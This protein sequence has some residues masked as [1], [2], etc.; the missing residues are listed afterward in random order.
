MIPILKVHRIFI[1]FSYFM[2]CCEHRNRTTYVLCQK[3]IA[4]DRLLIFKRLTLRF[5]TCV[6]LGEGL[7]RVHTFPFFFFGG[8]QPARSES[9]NSVSFPF[10][11]VFV[12][13]AGTVIRHSAN[14]YLPNQDRVQAPF[15][16]EMGLNPGPQTFTTH[17]SHFL[18]GLAHSINARYSNW[19][20]YIKSGFHFVQ[21]EALASD[22][23]SL[24]RKLDRGHF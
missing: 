24:K 6:S 20:D 3:H 2:A 11:F 10:S 1:I 17:V 9:A 8:G 4:N 18:C 13:V 23:R 7:F 14:R 19:E 5:E 15:F 22:G 16:L 21:L 12:E